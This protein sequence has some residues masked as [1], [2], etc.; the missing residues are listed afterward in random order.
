MSSPCW[1]LLALSLRRGRMNSRVHEILCLTE[2]LSFRLL[3]FRR[4]N[5]SLQ[6]SHLTCEFS[7]NTCE[8]VHNKE[9][10]ITVSSFLLGHA[11][12]AVYHAIK[13]SDSYPYRNSW[14]C[15][16][17]KS[18]DEPLNVVVL[19]WDM[20]IP[21]LWS[22]R[23]QTPGR[24]ARGRKLNM[25][26]TTWKTIV[27]LFLRLFPRQ[28]LRIPRSSVSDRPE[29]TAMATTSSAWP[30]CSSFWEINQN[31]AQAP[32]LPRYG[33]IWSVLCSLTRFASAHTDSHQTTIQTCV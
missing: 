15:Y 3:E 5:R 28:K 7:E 4:C 1:W 2:A 30:G 6:V 23:Y 18:F 33:V 12:H 22:L 24:K 14:I 25:E 9:I 8:N 13:L 10:N 16:D 11:K 31:H 29:R 21:S 27:W 20:S 17:C 26:T 19:K 32:H